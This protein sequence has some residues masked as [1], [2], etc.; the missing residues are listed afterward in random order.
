MIGFV[1]VAHGGLG[2]ALIDSAEMILG[3]Q[4]CVFDVSV[5]SLSMKI[6]DLREELLEIIDKA[7]QGDGV[8]VFTDLFGGTPSNLAISTLGIRNVEI[9][10]GVNLPMLLRGLILRGQNPRCTLQEVCHRTE[11]SGRKQISIVSDLVA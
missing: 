1:V 4:E 10:A 9:I 6:D 3:Q 2:R 8:L 5:S 7:D 11:E